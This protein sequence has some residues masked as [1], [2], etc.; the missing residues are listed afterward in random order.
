MPLSEQLL[1]A[2]ILLVAAGLVCVV[3][4]RIV[5]K[6]RPRAIAVP[7]SP[8]AFSVPYV[9]PARQVGPPIRGL[10]PEVPGV[11]ILM[12]GVGLLI[13]TGVLGYKFESR[14]RYQMRSRTA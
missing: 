8:S 3:L 7:I 13:V 6:P 14:R 2:G 4:S 10:R 12:V 11:G 5:A 9:T 1:I